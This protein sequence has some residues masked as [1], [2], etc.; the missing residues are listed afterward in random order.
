LRQRRET[1]GISW[2]SSLASKIA[3]IP[4]PRGTCCP[5]IGL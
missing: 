2:F 5:E 3:N 1:T 4:T